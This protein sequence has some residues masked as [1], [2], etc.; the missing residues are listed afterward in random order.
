[1]EQTGRVASLMGAIKIESAGTQNHSFT[2]DE[3][4]QRYEQAFSELA[5]FI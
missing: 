2:L 5:D 3:F 4:R 1:W